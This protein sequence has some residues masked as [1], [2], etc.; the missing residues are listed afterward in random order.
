MQVRKKV[1]AALAVLAVAVVVMLIVTGGG[2]SRDAAGTE[3]PTPA[4]AVTQTA[5]P[6]PA[7]ETTPEPEPEPVVEEV[8][9]G[10]LPLISHDAEA[11]IPELPVD[12]NPDGHA[13]DEVVVISDFT[14]VYDGPNG[15][16][17]AV[18]D[19]TP[20]YESGEW[21]ETRA[22]VFERDGAWVMIPVMARAGLPS[23]G[24]TGQAVGWIDTAIDT[25]TVQEAEGTTV[26]IDTSDF[27][28][29][30]RDARG[31]VLHRDEDA[32]VGRE[33]YST[34]PGRTAI[35]TSWIDERLDYTRDPTGEYH[36]VI[37]LA[38]FVDERDRLQVEATGEGGGPPLIAAHFY[39][40]TDSGR[41]SMGCVRVSPE[42]AQV[43]A[44]LPI[45]TPVYI[46]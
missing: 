25:V 37:A 30:V 42:H 38:R 45:G 43:L 34:S 21:I 16:P 5:T 7:V 17:V 36:P 15:T 1:V 24:V 18:L 3:Q 41:V 20:D 26:H 12:P 28:V 22:P 46:S 19:L 8:D 32:G 4:P 44:E 10:G 14:P 11:V 31:E 6:E 33:G 9:L 13:L 23:E 2:G 29:E 39:R 35:T 40:G 27:T